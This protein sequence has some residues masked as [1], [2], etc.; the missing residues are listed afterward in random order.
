MTNQF[1]RSL[2][3]IS[4]VGALAF[5]GVAQATNGYFS[6][7]YGLRNSAL[8]GAG[9]AQAQGS[10]SAA[11]NPAAMAFVGNSW[12]VGLS[13]F[14]PD[15]AYDVTGGP[16]IPA[17]DGVI[18]G[19]GLGP[20]SP[21]AAPGMAPCQLPFSIGP[22]SI[23]SSNKI[24]AIPNMGYNREINDNMTF[25]VSVYGNGGMNTLYKGGTAT[26]YNP[27]ADSIGPAPGTYGAGEAGVDLMQLFVQPSMSFKIG[28]S[29]AIGVGLII[30][31]QLF[32]AVGLDN[33]AGITNDSTALTGNGHDNA[34]GAGG[35]IGFMSQVSEAFS[36][37][38]S[39]QTKISMEEFDE[40]A[41]LFAEQGNFDIPST[42][43]VGIAFNVSDTNTVLL[44]V[45]R[46]N[47]S[48]VSSI[49]NSIM[50]LMDGRCMDA[51]NATLF[52]GM[53]SPAGGPGCLGGDE[54]AGFG[55]DDMTIVKLGYEWASDDTWTWR[56]GASF[57]NQPI[58][59]SEVLFNMIAPA[60]VETHLTFG[61]SKKLSDASAIDFAAMYAFEESVS[62]PS[63][64]D[65]SQ[66]IELSMS[67][68]QLSVG[69]TKN[70]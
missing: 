4:I 13:L 59:E 22:Q 39:Y 56:L 57:T 25:G 43:T 35:K 64:F 62:G 44:D 40:Y 26:M 24:F 5:T 18:S 29:S 66:T 23:T 12:E 53:P 54:G 63:S 38:A 31:Y 7:G 21:C 10:M 9:V 17:Y 65:P 19:G 6:H 30:G 60:V 61:F 15:R 8:G 52:G 67:Q 70:F 28:E 20:G 49:S 14:M 36:I 47:Y 34:T 58:P 3:T 55:W 41:G 33:F 2:L 69:Y 68:L 1:K 37:G 32:E 48:D 42:W 45:Q 51:L 16:A 50:P 46:I 27:F 11:T